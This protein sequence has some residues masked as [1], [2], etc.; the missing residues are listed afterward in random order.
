M[1]NK[2]QILSVAQA[3]HDM[4]AEASLVGNQKKLD[5]NDND[6]IDAADLAALRAGAK[7]NEAAQE[8]EAPAA[9][10]PQPTAEVPQAQAPE[11]PAPAPAPEAPDAEKQ[12]DDEEELDE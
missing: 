2:E 6:K 3:Y 10:E 7:A 9:D 1:T 11:A 5:V 4:V 8:P 12:D